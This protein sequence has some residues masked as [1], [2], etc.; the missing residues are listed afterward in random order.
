MAQA[1]RMTHSTQK[2]I[3]EYFNGDYPDSVYGYRTGTYLVQ[4]Y[5][6]RFGTPDLAT[7]PSRWTLCD[8]TIEYMYEKGRINDFFTTML[9]LRNVSKELKE[10]NKSVAAAKRRDAIDA[11][12]RILI[13]DDLELIELNNELILHRI[14]DDSDL[15]GSGGFANVY[16]V[17]GKNMVVKKLRDEFKGNEDVV[18]RFKYEFRLISEKLKGID[19]IIEGYEYD[20]DEIAYT[21]EYCNSDLKKYMAEYQLS[22]E[23]RIG[24]VLEILEI[25]KNVHER[26]VWHRDLSPKNIFIKNGHPVIADFGLG[27]AIDDDGRTYMTVDTSMNG[28]LEYCDP[29][30]FKGLRFADEQADIYSLGKIIN[31]VMTEN[32]DDFDHA[33]NLVSTIATETSLDARFHSVQE[34]IDKITMLTKSKADTEYITRCEKLLASGYYDSSMD[35]YL[36]SF[37][38]DNLIGH[39]NNANFRRIYTNIVSNPSYNKVMIERFTELHNIF[40]HPIGHTFASF[41][42]VSKF[43]VDTLRYQRGISPALKSILGQCI[44]D[45]AEGVNRWNAQ[46]YFDENY[47]YLEPQY[48][49]D[50]ILAAKERR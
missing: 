9:S 30:Q 45:I 8:D 38:D 47:Q 35:D 20:E 16:R 17:P 12:N 4:M 28:T 40:L 29:R 33:L 6:D 11:I 50:S 21:M 22:E 39:L 36:L 42:D 19:G 23:R 46:S 37:D 3:C 13:E 32:S 10:T 31:Y 41:D 49:Q 2:D 14:D 15:I 27:K 26:Q 25:M 43:C 34:M 7:G 24:L 5:T 48:V 18:S 44:Y 1:P